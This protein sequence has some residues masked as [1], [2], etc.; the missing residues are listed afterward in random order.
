MS[1]WLKLGIRSV[2]T[3]SSVPVAP[4][5]EPEGPPQSLPLLTYHTEM[6]CPMTSF[7]L[8]SWQEE[9]AFFP[10]KLKFTERTPTPLHVFTIAS[11]HT[12]TPIP[13]GLPALKVAKAVSFSADQITQISQPVQMSTGSSLSSIDS[14]EFKIP[15]PDSEAGRPSCGGYNL[16]KALKWDADHF[17]AFKEYVHGSIQTHCDTSKSKASQTPTMITAVQI[18]NSMTMTAVGQLE[19]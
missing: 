15:K 16:E 19:I 14:H 8:V 3:W 2:M 13:S 6:F 9:M 12:A 17:K 5:Y 18:E 7:V 1:F 10:P 11:S 4:F